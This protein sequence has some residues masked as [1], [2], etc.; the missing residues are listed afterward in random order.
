VTYFLTVLTIF[1]SSWK[2]LLCD[3]K[4]KS[5]GEIEELELS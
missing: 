2:N 5:G 1:R 3:E 4:L